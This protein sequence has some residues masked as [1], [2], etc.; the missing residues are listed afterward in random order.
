VP[1][2]GATGGWAKPGWAGADEKNTDALGWEGAG[3]YAELGWDA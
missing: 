1:K 3:V 2:C